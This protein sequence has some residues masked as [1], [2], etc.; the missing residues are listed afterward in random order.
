[1]EVAGGL[2]SQIWGGGSDRHPGEGCHPDRPGGGHGGQRAGDPVPQRCR[3]RQGDQEQGPLR[4][5][6]PLRRPERGG[7]ALRPLGAWRG[8]GPWSS[9]T[10]RWGGWPPPLLHE[11]GCAVTSPCAAT[12][13]ARPWCPPGAPSPPM[14]SGTTPWRGWT[15]CSAATTSP[16]YTVAAYELAA[17]ARPP[18]VLADLAIPRDIE[19]GGGGA[20]PASPFTTWTTWGWRCAGTSPRRRRRFCKIP[21]PAGAVG[22][23]PLLPAGLERVK[24][25]VTARVR[26]TDLDGPGGPGPW[27]SWR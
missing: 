10:G 23:L 16:H 18:K 4:G 11:A 26:S 27:W 2:R 14:R 13:T 8:S 24:Q 20:A 1:M 7:E 19:P 5:G 21:G 17:L 9:A 6:A 25:A 3:R 22:E 15:W 12:T